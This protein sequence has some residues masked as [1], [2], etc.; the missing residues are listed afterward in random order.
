MIQSVQLNAIYKRIFLGSILL[1]L[2]LGTEAQQISHFS[3]F[4]MAPSALNPALTGGFKGTYR[5]NGIYRSQW[6]SYSNVSNPLKTFVLSG[7]FNLKGGLLLENDWLSAG[8][9]LYS[10][11]GGGT[12]RKFS[13]T[14]FSIGYH[15]GLD[16]DYKNVFSAGLKY[17][18]IGSTLDNAFFTSDI[19]DGTSQSSIDNG[20]GLCSLSGC[21]NGQNNTPRGSDLSLGI[22]YK[23]EVNDNLFKV[24]LAFMSINGAESTVAQSRGGPTDPTDPTDPGNPDP[25]I[26]PNPINNRKVDPLQ[27]VLSLYG[28]AST[29]LSNR[30]RLNPAMLMATSGGT[31]ELQLQS[32]ADYLINPKEQFSL[33]GGL[34]IR[35]VPFDAAYVIAGVIVKDLSVRLT[36]DLNLGSLT[37]GGRL[38]NTFEISVG[39][40]GRIYKEAKSDKV[41][42]CPRL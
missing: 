27:S 2:T 25:P 38:P 35:P 21:N 6:G 12:G 11:K 18:N 16:D 7:E 14:A 8:A 42:F 29:L 13:G 22:A 10:D 36:Y 1:F 9:S 31:F 40:V 30:L 28:E 33:T 5:A 24:G 39:Y 17:G 41:I 19:N 26:D 20:E 15:I 3:D 4:R 37:G 34:G 32:T 23:T